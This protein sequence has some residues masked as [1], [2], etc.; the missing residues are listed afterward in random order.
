[1]NKKEIEEQVIKMAKETGKIGIKCKDF[2]GYPHVAAVGW[3]ATNGTDASTREEQIE[4]MAI[5]LE[6][7]FVLCGTLS[8]CGTKRCS[9]CFSKYLYEQ[10]YRKVPEDSVVLSREELSE[11]PYNDFC[12][13]CPNVRVRSSGM[14]DCCADYSCEQFQKYARLLELYEQSRKET[15]KEI[16]NEILFVESV[17]GWEE[18]EQLVKFGNKIVDKI[19]ELAKKYGVE[20][21]K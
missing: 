2:C 9:R 10:G 16:L 1:M 17:E 14:T 7:E 4:E 6:E 13:G 11:E 21:E 20:I 12:K 3:E 19:E 8:S 5:G 18:N 15:A